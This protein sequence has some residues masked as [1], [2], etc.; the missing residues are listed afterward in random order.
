MSKAARRVRLLTA[1]VT[2]VAVLGLT[3]CGSSG[4]AGGPGGGSDPIKVGAVL[5]LTGGNATYGVGMSAAMNL[6]VKD[7][8]AAGGPLGRQL[9]LYVEDDQSQASN[10]V[11]AA[12]KLVS[13]DK[14]VAVTGLYGSSQ[15]LAAAPVIVKS[16]TVMMDAASAP[17][18]FQIGP[19]AFQFVPPEA[20]YSRV[21]AR[22]AQEQGYKH[23][24]VLAVNNSSGKAF[25]DEFEKA[26]K[27]AG[28]TIDSVSLYAPNQS[29]Y[30]AELGKAMSSNPDGIA[31]YAYT[32]DATVLLKEAV[33]TG[34]PVNWVG[35]KFGFNEDAIKVLPANSSQSVY[36]VDVV[37][38][39]ENPAYKAY[40][41][42]Y[43]AKT[44]AD[45]ANNPFAGMA[46]DMITSLALAIQESGK[47]DGQSI[48]SG[49]H[50]LSVPNGTKVSSYKD[51]LAAVKSNKPIALQ[52]VSGPLTFSKAD[53][54]RS[55][56]FGVY[57]ATN[58]KLS[59]TQTIDASSL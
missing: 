23:M 30:T 7:V 3:A 13:V 51:A 29:N 46:Y 58:G 24:S 45:P 20:I 42:E 26:F 9:K 47:T 25:A 12:R 41:T 4:S 32:P 11:N 35:P 21:S 1:A 50:Q 52:G 37:L 36:A 2:T 16:N 55:A 39:N 8:N 38:S 27:A 15:T 48:A 10:D 59:L 44:S 19:L 22:V 6:A 56:F 40:S 54:S 17:E 49:L 5:P 31:A 33:A 28:G 43:Q 57:K 14:V 18:A 34:K 53:N